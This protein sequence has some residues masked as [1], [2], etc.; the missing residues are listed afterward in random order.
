MDVSDPPISEVVCVLC[1][2]EGG[3]VDV[4]HSQADMRYLV[5]SLLIYYFV[6]DE[7]K[8]ATKFAGGGVCPP[9]VGFC[10]GE[11]RSRG[12]ARVRFCPGED[13]SR[14]RRLR[15]CRELRMIWL[16]VQKL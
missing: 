5:S 14:R 4:L 16:Y 10:P 13:F 3:F 6:L 7:L 12:S 2:S 1:T 8:D 15:L 9:L 11:V